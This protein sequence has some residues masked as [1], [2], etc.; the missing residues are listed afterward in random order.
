MN[1]LAVSTSTES[2]ISAAYNGSAV[3]H[4]HHLE[5]PEILLPVVMRALY[6]SI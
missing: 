4:K 6:L 5:I 1:E 2:G 3:K